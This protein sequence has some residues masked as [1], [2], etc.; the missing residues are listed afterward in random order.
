MTKVA[1][2]IPT[3]ASEA[4]MPYL[5]LCVES[6]RATV[7]WPI[8]VVTNGSSNK[9]DLK[10]IKGI[11]THLHTPKQGQCIASN[12][13]AQIA[14][15]GTDYLFIVNDD[16]VFAP[17]WNKNLN[18]R[19]PVFSPNLIEPMNNHGSA[20]PFLKVNGGFTLDEFNQAIVDE[21]VQ[22]EVNKLTGD[23]V[24]ETGFNLPFFIEKDLWT[25]LNGYDIA[26]DPWSSNSDTDLQT[27]INLAGVIPMRLRNVLVYHFSNKSGTFSPENDAFR[28]NNFEYFMDK[29]GFSRDTVPGCDVWYNRNMLP[30]D[31][32]E[33][34]YKQAKYEA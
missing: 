16:M 11:T 25:L 27:R 26:Y 22:K 10:D 34:K 1:V 15:D 14:P 21:F 2:I 3:L 5:K 19:F 7:D 28:M 6:L 20:E 4:T 23:P 9:P 33:I 17:N 8:I 30:E 18:F 24:I 31:K 12:Y 32:T 13:G 29:F